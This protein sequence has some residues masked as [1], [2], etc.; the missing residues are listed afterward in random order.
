M[1]S[2]SRT[3]AEA[4][5]AEMA[6]IRDQVLPAYEDPFL[7]G[8]GAFAAA[9]MR[10]DLDKAAKAMVEGDTVAMLRSYEALKGYE[11]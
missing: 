2:Q 5:P 9:M 8:A 3:L 1:T 4:L 6:R 10:A 7:K 11:T